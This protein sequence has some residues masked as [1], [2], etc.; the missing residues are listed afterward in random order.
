M[1][2][3][4][5][6]TDAL[7]SWNTP[8]TRGHRLEANRNIPLPKNTLARRPGMVC[9][10]VV[11]IH[12]EPSSHPVPSAKFRRPEPLSPLRFIILPSNFSL[13]PPLSPPRPPLSPVAVPPMTPPA[14][15]K[16]L[17]EKRPPSE[18]MK[19]ALKSLALALAGLIALP[20]LSCA[21]PPLVKVTIFNG[22]MT[23]SSNNAETS[24][25]FLS[26]SL[27]SR[28]SGGGSAESQAAATFGVLRAKT[29]ARQVG[30]AP[31]GAPANLVSARYRDSR[32]TNAPGRAGQTGSVTVK[33]TIT[34]TL[35][36]D[37]PPRPGSGNQHLAAAKVELSITSDDGGARS[38]LVKLSSREF[39][40]MD[41]LLP[42]TPASIS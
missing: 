30:S 5:Y 25:S 21:L 26:R 32:V 42:V 31:F 41:S 16:F 18:M 12:H 24:S 19:S 38:A 15:S 17:S 20:S 14:K 27:A 10:G 29:E 37:A 8:D 4:G 39:T 11:Q 1:V 6:S 28:N 3:C 22:S 2:I 34:G 23:P 40:R 13:L 35:K 9:S 36:I 7:S 33:F